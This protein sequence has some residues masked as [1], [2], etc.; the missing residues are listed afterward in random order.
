MF[1]GA[2]KCNTTEEQAAFCSFTIVL[3]LLWYC[4]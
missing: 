3:Y 2:Y 1:N 4:T